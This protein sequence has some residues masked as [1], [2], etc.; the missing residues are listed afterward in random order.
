[1]KSLRTPCYVALSVILLAAA[2]SAPAADWPMHR[3][4]VSRGG[5]VDEQLPAQ[6]STRWTFTPAQP[7]WPAWPEPGRELNRLAFDYCFHCSVAD[8]VVYFGSSATGK[9][10]ALDLATGAERWSFFTGG[11]V[12]FAPAVANGRVYVASDDGYLYCL[13]AADGAQL[14]R[15]RAGPRDEM[16]MGHD[17]LISRW[18][19][20]CGCAVVGDT[21]YTVGGIFPSEGVYVYALSCE[22]GSVRWCNDTSGTIY[23]NQPHPGSQ[24][25]TGVAPQGPVMV[26]AGRL[27]VP[28]GRNVPA[29]Y[30]LET[31]ALVYYHG[32]PKNWNDRWG[33]TW[34]MGV[35]GLFMI[36]KAHV[37][38]DIEA[39]YGESDPWPKDGSTLMNCA[40]G[41][42]ACE[43]PGK[44]CATVGTGRLYAV[45]DGKVTAYDLD[46]LQAG[47]APTDCITWQADHPYAYDIIRAG[48]TLLVGGRDTLTAFSATDGKRHWQQNLGAQVRGIAAA[49]GHLL[50]AL[51]DG[52]VV[53]FGAGQ[54]A[55][56]EVGQVAPPAPYP[57]DRA[58]REA[59]EQAKRVVAGTGFT[60]GY[61][62]LLGA[63]D[64]RLAYELT[65]LGEFTVFGV[66][67]DAEKVSAARAALDAAGLYGTRATIHQGSLDA[68]ALP[69]YLGNLVVVCTQDGSLSEAYRVCRPEGGVL[70][71]LPGAEKSRLLAAGA[72]GSEIVAAGTPARVVRGKL[73]GAG[74]WTHQYSDAA[75]TACSTDHRARLPLQMLWFGE[76]GPE[77][78]VNRHWR[79]S[80]PVAADGRVFVGGQDYVI[81]SDAY[82]G[83]ELWSWE[84]PKVGR[85]SAHAYGGNLAVN[86]D[87]LYVASGGVC[88]RLD[89]ATG[90]RMAMYTPPVGQETLSLA[91]P[92]EL[93]LEGG[94][95]QSGSVRVAASE[96]A[97]EMTLRTVDETVTNAAGDRPPGTGDSWELYLDFRPRELAGGKYGSGAF[98]I[99]I[100]PATV[101][102]PSARWAHVSGPECP[103][104]KVEGKLTG[105]GSE[106]TVSLAWDEVARL[107]GAGRPADFGFAVTLNCS[108][109]GKK[110]VRRVH[111]FADGDS[112]RL[113]THWA[114][115]V[116]DETAIAPTPGETGSLLPASEVEARSWE[117]L[118]VAGGTVYGS[119]GAGAEASHVFALDAATGAPKW[120]YTAEE[121]V[122]S[123][124]I[125][126]TDG[127]VVLLDRT[128]DARLTQMKR[129]G[130]KMQVR[131]TLKALDAR[132]GAE[133]WTTRQR[134]SDLRALF[135]S[136]GVLLATGPTAMNAY[137]VAD[138]HMM[139]A[140]ATKTNKFPA[141]VDGVIYNEPRAYD[142]QTGEQA[143]RVHPLTGQEVGW[144]YLRSYGCG[145][146]AGAPGLLLFRSGTVGFC[147]LIEDSGIHN[148][149]GVRAGC[150]VN[151][152]AAN[153]LVMVPCADAGCTC[154]YNFQ[155]SVALMPAE[156]EETWSVFRATG[157]KA[158]TPLKRVSLNLGAPGDRRDA[159]DAVWLS[160]PRP[161]AAG[162]MKIAAEMSPAGETNLYRYNA[163]AIQISGTQHPWLYA[164][165]CTGAVKLSIATLWEAPMGLPVSETRPYTVRLHFAEPTNTAQGQRVFGVKLQ[166]QSALE[167]FDIAA[168]AGGA[169][170]ALVKE[171]TGVEAGS[172]IDIEL[173]PVTGDPLLCAVDIIEE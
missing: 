165:G 137:R 166:G 43:L 68:L 13:S 155:T 110:V 75:K 16:V 73:P 14:W 133:V 18:P 25:M 149:G 81:A 27:F 158:L 107:T 59:A 55:P 148:Y 113:T 141:I 140:S 26:H 106:T 4:D 36:P 32:A 111:R 79:A 102:H 41:A 119:L 30:D 122:N 172:S 100:V 161:P 136:A 115:M 62:V 35:D 38:P 57:D 118:A 46:G 56:P 2:V 108:D 45:G 153:G 37:G 70:C 131:Y 80:S 86:G 50:A 20:R 164:S 9:V 34:T 83:R 130:E 40:D 17:R 3:A 139:W 142:L 48:D 95:N 65:K 89:A 6:M 132:T 22:D 85:Q 152:I 74:E 58:M 87:S 72:T 63:G 28:T 125:V 134:I 91:Q 42:A 151:A 77:R 1:M 150:Y 88:F 92:V 76:P 19:L 162:A 8:G 160:F 157:A 90:E 146:I 31:G 64:G 60:G 144:D 128:P 97:L 10:H 156:R 12:R 11:P 98:R 123:N 93:T 124:A 147:D 121:S 39:R 173:V 109:D 84:L 169:R 117:H 105:T 120:V 168:E 138:G 69:P 15:F 47:K 49:D 23:M 126:V 171:I 116:L 61:C 7:P 53:C 167:D 71:V 51:N 67:P 114:R 170:R 112:W 66:E 82:N 103:E 127:L 24:A 78:L 54:Q 163:D 154:S 101:E 135:S 96:Q 99:G 21:V 94:K 29:A 145:S 44:L 5:A 159:D 129:R 104:M 143:R 33:G 52:R